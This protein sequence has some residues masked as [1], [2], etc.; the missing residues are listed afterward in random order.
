MLWN[1]AAIGE[2]KPP[3]DKG[4]T[5]HNLGGRR[6]GG[7]VRERALSHCLRA[8]SLT[9][10]KLFSQK[11]AARRTEEEEG[12]KGEAGGGWKGRAEVGEEKRERERE[13]GE[14]GKGLRQNWALSASGAEPPSRRAAALA[15]SV[16]PEQDPRE[17][18]N[19]IVPRRWKPVSPG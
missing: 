13:R 19:G 12:T 11:T 16:D 1:S 9:G 17:K 8:G 7:G 18:Q 2:F 5:S 3:R 15:L 6:G 10:A 4:S 14:R